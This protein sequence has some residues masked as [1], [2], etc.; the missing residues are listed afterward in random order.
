MSD[1]EEIQRVVN[2]YARN[3]DE[4]T[5]EKFATEVFTSDANVDVGFGALQGIDQ[6]VRE[7]TTEIQK[8]EATVHMNANLEVEIDGDTARSTMNVTF[9]H[10][11]AA[12]GEADDATMGVDL[13]VYA[14]QLTRGPEGWRIAHRRFR[15]LGPAT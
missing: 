5:P 14:D 9:W 8:F 11:A 4:R 3:I 1:I 10:W 13:G 12:E 2:A 7:Y 15:M 6:I